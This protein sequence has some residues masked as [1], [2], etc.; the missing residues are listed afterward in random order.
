MYNLELRARESIFPALLQLRELPHGA[1]LTSVLG[2]YCMSL[3][4][5]RA[6]ADLRSLFG[7]LSRSRG[8]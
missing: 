6:E 3:A 7:L 5:S 8:I 4:L 2:I 1:F